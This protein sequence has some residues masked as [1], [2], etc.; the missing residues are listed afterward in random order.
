MKQTVST[1]ENQVKEVAALLSK[2][3]KNYQMYLPNNRMFISS[4]DAVKKALD[5]F[6][7]ENG[8]LTFVVKEFELI[9]EDVPVYVNMDKHQSIAFRMYRDGVRLLSFHK[10]L[11][12]DE[13][14]AFFEALTR[15]IETDNS[16]E[17][18]VTLLWARDL[19]A[20]TYYEVNE[21][22]ADCEG[23]E[24][25]SKNTLANAVPLKP[26]FKQDRPGR[27]S[28]DVEKLKPALSLS[29]RDVEEV[30]GLAIAVDDDLFLRRAWHVLAY[31]LEAEEAKDGYPDFENGL[32]GFLDTCV[33]KRQLGMA[34]D[35]LASIRLQFDQCETEEVAQTLTRIVASR[36]TE[37]NME[38]IGETLS[39]GR[40]VE[41]VQ[42]LAY[43]SR[44]SDDAI[45]S[46]LGLLP[47]CTR[48]SAKQTVIAA[49]ASLG[50]GCP[51]EIV[52]GVDEARSDDVEVVL[53]VLDMIGT[54]AALESAM[55][56]R[57]H[58]APRIRARVASLAGSLKTDS[59]LRIVN[60]LLNDEDQSV[61]RRAV[62][63]LV[64]IGGERCAETL[65]ELYTSKEF[66]LL[67]HNAKRSMLLVTRNLPPSGQK[68]IIQAVFGMRNLLK[69]KPVEDT[70]VALGEIIHLM[71]RNVA[72]EILK[73][74]VSKSS[75][76]VRKTLESA[77]ERLDL[78]GRIH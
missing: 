40:E 32:I 10:G 65:T 53:D 54:E 17:D 75:G 24:K 37:R 30:R 59:S 29:A 49:L 9:H 57:H 13:L 50:G 36:Y 45:P 60:D 44:L 42:C 18:F 76:S 1:V 61:R 19:Q 52:R 26:D 20:I 11:T 69:K 31:T 8:I 72:A 48:Q 56:L 62:V 41:Q 12:D 6:L 73:K 58:P 74:V 43:L 66:G 23:L 4:R 47:S 2:A 3:T 33:A 77:L 51:A 16:E 14:L 71:N 22:E 70:K 39:A 63:S 55:Q 7:E 25:S 5:C 34:A 35:A 15:C 78:A 64:K 68:Q 67:P 46:I 28:E 21:F 38:V 27:I